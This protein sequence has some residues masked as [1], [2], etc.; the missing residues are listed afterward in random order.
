M[1]L[2]DGLEKRSRFFFLD[3]GD[4][5]DRE[6]DRS[7]GFQT[8]HSERRMLP[9]GCLLLLNQHWQMGN[10]TKGRWIDAPIE[11]RVAAG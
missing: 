8:A 11:A 2:P 4:A 7:I 5:V 10:Q 1:D 9:V 6:S 3:R